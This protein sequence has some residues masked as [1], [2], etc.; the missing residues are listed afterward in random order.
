MGEPTIDSIAKLHK[1]VKRNAQRVP[2]TLGGGQNGYLGLV[3]T[4]EVYNTIPGA[5][6]FHRPQD[7]GV[8][9]P[10]PRRVRRV[11]TR[12]HQEVEELTAEDIA[13]QR[14]Q[15]EEQLRLY[16]EVQAIEGLLRTQII[17]A[18]DEQYITALRSPTT[19]MIH[20][21][22]PAIFSFL[23]QTYGQLSPQELNEREREL[24]NFVFDPSGHVNMV[25][26]RLQEF[27]DICILV[28]QPKQDYQLTNLAYI[29]FQKEPAFR[30]SLLRW[31][32]R[33][34]NKTYQDFV[35]FMREEFREMQKVGGIT[36]GTSNIGGVNLVKELQDIKLHTEKL[37][38]NM[39]DEIRNTMQAFYLHQ[40]EP[41]T[42]KPPGPELNYED[43]NMQEQQFHNVFAVQQQQTN[44]LQQLSKQL[45]MLQTQLNSLTPTNIKN[46]T[47]DTTINPKTG[48]PY[49]RYCWTCGCCTHWSKNCPKKAKGHKN[50]A[51][52]KNR[53]G[54]SNA[55]CL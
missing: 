10:T 49:R 16:N 23:M 14:I 32:R 22:I 25:F 9:T 5:R 37:A 7:P 39:Q 51:T 42:W 11:V 38:S 44:A 18:I 31:N 41:Q 8:F 28:Q 52:F 40:Q 27:Q 30:D 43:T 19:D 29:I 2:T 35:V 1:E 53:M 17:E 50:E 12:G 15:Y 47:Q 55:N 48:Q 26:N 20:E 24:D 6:P 45:S 46:P 3:V 54:G 33:I 21:S 34:E 4:P 13:M 36:V